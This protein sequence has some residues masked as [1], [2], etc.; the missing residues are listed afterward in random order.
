MVGFYKDSVLVYVPNLN[1]VSE[2]LECTTPTI[3]EVE[4]HFIPYADHFEF[5]FEFVPENY[6]IE[7]YN[8]TGQLFLK[9][10]VQSRVISYSTNDLRAG[11]YLIIIYKN[12]ELIYKVKYV[13]LA[14]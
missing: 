3:K 11:L 13:H 8:L 7:V 2:L 10:K 6:S 5:H 4:F 9:Q 1:Y 12:N 14:R